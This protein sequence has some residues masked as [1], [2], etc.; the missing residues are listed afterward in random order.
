MWRLTVAH[1]PP[2]QLVALSSFSSIHMT[3]KKTAALTNNGANLYEDILQ[4]LTN[5]RAG[6]HW[7]PVESRHS[8]TLCSVFWL[9]HVTVTG[10]PHSLSCRC[11]GCG[12][13]R[14]WPSVCSARLPSASAWSPVGSSAAPERRPGEEST[15]LLRSRA[16]TVDAAAERLQWHCGYLDA[17]VFSGLFR[18]VQFFPQNVHS[19][20]QLFPLF[21]FPSSLFPF[22]AQLSMK[23]WQRQWCE[24]Q[25]AWERQTSKILL[26]ML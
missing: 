16:V 21:V 24:H 14:S 19:L 22:S 17:G 7:R 15:S 23:T 20:L 10:W 4:E 11:S 13:W 9:H 6:F 26:K 2:V 18:F 12:S 5:N 3:T 8:D 25:R 1:Y